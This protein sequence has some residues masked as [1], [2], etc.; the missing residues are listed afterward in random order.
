[1]ISPGGFAVGLAKT[2]LKTALEAELRRVGHSGC[3]GGG[4][5]LDVGARRSSREDSPRP[6][7]RRRSLGFAG[8]RR[9]ASDRLL[10]EHANAALAHSKSGAECSPSHGAGINDGDDQP[11]PHVRDFLGNLAQILI[12]L[13]CDP[14]RLDL[15]AIG[16]EA[17]DHIASIRHQPSRCLGCA[18]G[19]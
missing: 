15:V 19:E 2:V 9:P 11:A 6:F 14:H 8:L 13:E 4:L 5:R 7:P 16:L 10:V 3:L 18:H 17:C 1:M 12:E